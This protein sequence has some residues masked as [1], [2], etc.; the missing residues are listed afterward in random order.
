MGETEKKRV[1]SQAEELGENGL[2]KKQKE[3]DQ[4]VEENEVNRLNAYIILTMIRCFSWQV[5][6]QLTLLYISDVMYINV[7]CCCISQFMLSC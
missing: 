5:H 2:A 3:L 6:W 1:A 7:W 4:A